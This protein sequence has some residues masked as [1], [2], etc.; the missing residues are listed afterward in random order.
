[1]NSDSV[2]SMCEKYDEGKGS[3]I[4][5]LEDVQAKY[6]YLPENVLRSIAEQTGRSLVDIYGV[7]TFYKAFSLKPRGKHLISV[8]L[9]MLK[10][11]LQEPMNH[12][13]D[14]FRL[15]TEVQSFLMR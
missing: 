7:A 1:M 8:C 5:I 2:A 13:Q 3:L 9:D 14:S 11:L 15:Q 4:A 12:G 10:A 6:S